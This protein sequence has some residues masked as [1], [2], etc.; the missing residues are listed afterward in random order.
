MAR[1]R[2]LATGTSQTVR[3]W[4]DIPATRIISVPTAAE[5]KQVADAWRARGRRLWIAGSSPG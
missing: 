1:S 3:S 2:S 5:L 4:C